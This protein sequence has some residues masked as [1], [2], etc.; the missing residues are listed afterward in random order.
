MKLRHK[1]IYQDELE[2]GDTLDDIMEELDSGDVVYFIC[3]EG[4]PTGDDPHKIKAVLMPVGLDL[5]KVT[6]NVY[7]TVLHE[8]GVINLPMYLTNKLGWKLGDDINAEVT[9]CESG[10]GIVLTKIGDDN[11]LSSTDQPISK[12]MDETLESLTSHF[13]GHKNILG[14]GSQG[15]HAITVYVKDAS[16]HT[17]LDMDDIKRV[18]GIKTYYV[19]EVGKLKLD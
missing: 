8:G 18:G 5:S 15:S 10:P 2:T 7:E 9:E 13:Q 12:E 4:L 3:E 16:L 1:Q 11:N 14:F 6:E 17:P 19:Q